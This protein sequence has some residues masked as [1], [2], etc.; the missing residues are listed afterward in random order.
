MNLAVRRPSTD[1]GRLDVRRG[2][3]LRG[4]LIGGGAVLAIIIA[5]RA[6]FSDRDSPAPLNTS[7]VLGIITAVGL[8]AFVGSQIATGWER[9][10]LEPSAP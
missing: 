8:G 2:N 7:R 3:A 9:V 10:P 1:V 6:A 5:G 4:A